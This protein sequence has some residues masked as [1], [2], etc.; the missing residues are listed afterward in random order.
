MPETLDDFEGLLDWPK[1]QGWIAGQDLPGNGPVSAVERLAGGSQNNVFLL[2]RGDAKLVLRRPPEHPRSNSDKT[3]LREARVLAALA[4]SEVPHPRFYGVCDDTGVIGACFY[5]MEPVVGFT[6]MGELPGRYAEDPAWRR[7]LGL[8][9]VDAIAELAKVDPLAVGLEGFGKPEQWIERQVARWKSQLDSYSEMEGYGKPEL[10]GVERVAGY[11]D[12]RRPN[13]FRLGIIHG[14]FQHANVMAHHD[15]PGVAA[16]IDWELSTLGDPRLDLAWLLTA[17]VEEG[18]P[19]GMQPYYSP[20]DGFPS[21]QEL[22]DHYAARTGL[23]VRDIHWWFTLACYKLGI[24]LEGTHARACAGAA[25]KH[26]GDTLHKHAMWLFTK[27]N[28][29]VDQA[30]D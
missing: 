3:M 1:L 26:Y 2:T 10:P 21:R 25:P 24:L 30:G 19:P 12:E 14:D 29:L 22:I 23:A 7:A 17:F 16:I 15:R 8:S 5:L 13:D 18:D 6:P 28:Q 20:A 4:G 27:A 11:L 9:L